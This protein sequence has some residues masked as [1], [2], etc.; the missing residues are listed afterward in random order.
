MIEISFETALAEQMV[1]AFDQKLEALGK[2]VTTCLK[3]KQHEAVA[4]IKKDI[5]QFHSLKVELEEKIAAAA[6]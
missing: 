6:K 5:A 4:L 1:D 2:V 3:A